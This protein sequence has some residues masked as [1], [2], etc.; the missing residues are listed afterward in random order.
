MQDWIINEAEQLEIE[1]QQ[2]ADKV[3]MWWKAPE[4][5][6]E[7]EIMTEYPAVD[8]VFKDKKELH[9]LVD[10][11]EKVWTVS[12]KSP[13]YR[14]LIRALKEGKKKFKL[15]RIGTGASDTR[16]SLVVL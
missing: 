1:A 13:L 3:G 16:Y 2:N 4:G 5:T 6:T 7:I 10:S 15:I 14:D 12:K 11:V 8:S 9:I